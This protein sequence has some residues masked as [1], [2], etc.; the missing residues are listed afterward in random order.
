MLSPTLFNI[1][2]EKIFAEALTDLEVSIRIN[3]E[4]LNN[5]R[6]ADDTVLLAT[7][8][9]DLQLLVDRVRAASETYGL[10]LNTKKTKFM[11][12]SRT[13]STWRTDGGKRRD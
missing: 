1:Y 7:N 2:S 11:V 6:Y 12:I 13:R 3:G 4:Y 5:I 9:K 8:L 10:E